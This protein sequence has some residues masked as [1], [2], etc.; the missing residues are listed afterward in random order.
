MRVRS[1]ASASVTAPAEIVSAET[2]WRIALSA[3]EMPSSFGLNAAR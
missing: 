1:F 3:S 2:F